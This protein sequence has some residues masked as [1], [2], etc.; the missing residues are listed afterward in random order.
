MFKLLV[1]MFNANKFLPM[2]LVI[3]SVDNHLHRIGLCL[4]N[5]YQNQIRI[6]I[7]KPIIVFSVLFIQLLKSVLF[8]NYNNNN[9][10]VYLGGIYSLD[11]SMKFCMNIIIILLNCLS[12][13]AIIIWFNNYKNDIKPTF[14]KVFQMM[15]GFITPVSIGLINREDIMCLLNRTR[16]LFR[17]TKF[18]NDQITPLLASIFSIGLYII[19]C[20]TFEIIIYG[21]PNTIFLVLMSHHDLNIILYHGCYFY[22]MFLLEYKIEEKFVEYL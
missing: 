16:I 22:I 18:N 11:I 2:S 8:L 20:N 5:R 13:S 1:I 10:F 19:F 12:M 3:D 4:E 15:S 17:I 7:Y 21:L 14:L 9:I 6:F